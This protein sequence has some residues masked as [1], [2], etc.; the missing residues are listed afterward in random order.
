MYNR[1]CESKGGVSRKERMAGLGER[2]KKREKIQIKK[3]AKRKECR[4]RVPTP[5]P[6]LIYSPKLL[7]TYYTIITF[8]SLERKISE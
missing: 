6:L 7:M 4:L 8:S 3:K 5:L 2:R 1:Y